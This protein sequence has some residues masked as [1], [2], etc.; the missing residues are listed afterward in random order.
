MAQQGQGGSN[1]PGDRGSMAPLDRQSFAKKFGGFA[2]LIAAMLFAAY[3]FAD[4]EKKKK[5]ETEDPDGRITAPSVRGLDLKEPNLEPPPEPEPLPPSEPERI[6]IAEMTPPP[7]DDS[8]LQRRMSSGFSSLA[9]N[10]NNSPAESGNTLPSSFTMTTAPA[11]AAPPAT[12]DSYDGQGVAKVTASRINNRSLL[13]TQGAKIPCT[14]ETAL[15]SSVPGMTSCIVSQDVYSSDG[16]VRLIDRGSKLNG[17]YDSDLKLGQVRIAIV[18]DRLETPEG[19]LVN[20]SSP[21]TDPLGRAGASGW[22]DTHFWERFG[23]AI[24]FSLV[25]DGFQYLNYKQARNDNPKYF[26]DTEAAAQEMAKIALEHEIDLKPTLHKNQGDPIMVFLNKDLSFETVYDLDFGNK[27]FS[28]K[29]QYEDM[30][31][32]HSRK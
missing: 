11:E 19:V 5:T 14:L 9:N 24:M 28:L 10:R 1:I 22:V 18:W 27:G 30:M 7:E 6:T 12:T 20:L 32:A 8:I 2:L 23:H 16:L 26:N 17:R 21:S 4:S 13:L 3:I 31:R 15:D 25:S 29:Q